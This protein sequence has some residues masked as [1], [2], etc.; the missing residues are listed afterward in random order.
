MG[1][2][3]WEGGAG[4]RGT[5]SCLAASRMNST[6]RSERS[7]SICRFSERAWRSASAESSALSASL[8]N[9]K[10]LGGSRT[11]S[12]AARRVATAEIRMHAKRVC[13]GAL[14]NAAGSI[15]DAAS[16]ALFERANPNGLRSLASVGSLATSKPGSA[17]CRQSSVAIS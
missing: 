17:P 5:D 15:V 10:A 2:R 1:T 7:R 9:R 13:A 8:L 6:P 11:A 4:E 3:L 12:A 16:K 14:R